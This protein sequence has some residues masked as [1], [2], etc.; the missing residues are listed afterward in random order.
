MKAVAPGDDVAAQLVLGA[1]VAVADDGLVVV[2]ALDGDV[3]AL[4]QQR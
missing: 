2:E 4:E 3:L 1:L